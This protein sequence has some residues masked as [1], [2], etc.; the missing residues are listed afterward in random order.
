[1][2]SFVEDGTYIH[3]ARCAC[4]PTRTAHAHLITTIPPNV[5]RDL[6]FVSAELHIAI[7]ASFFVEIIQA[8]ASPT[9]LLCL[10][11]ITCRLP[12]FARTFLKFTT[13]PLSSCFV[14]EGQHITFVVLDVTFFDPCTVPAT[15][16]RV[17]LLSPRFGASDA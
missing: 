4:T 15:H 6:Q 12:H 1:M 9:S 2:I 16:E 17:A 14:N 13:L 11:P 7:A 10:S 5:A 3:R 8:I